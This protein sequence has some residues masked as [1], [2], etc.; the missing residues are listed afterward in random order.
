[1]RS[2]LFEK[3]RVKLHLHTNTGKYSPGMGSNTLN[4]I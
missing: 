4:G 2:D 1:M 3:V